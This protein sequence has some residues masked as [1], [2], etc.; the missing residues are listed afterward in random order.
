MGWPTFR[1]VLREMTFFAGISVL[2]VLWALVF[3][4]A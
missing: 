1:V 4:D 3:V 2:D